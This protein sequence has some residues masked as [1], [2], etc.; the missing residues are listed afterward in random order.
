MARFSVFGGNIERILVLHV[1]MIGLKGNILVF[2]G[3]MERFFSC[4][5][6]EVW[7]EWQ[8]SVFGGNME[9]ILVLH[10]EMIGLDGNILIFDG[11]LERILV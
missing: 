9:R 1:D 3:N 6:R 2:D 5:C 11:N 4:A 8:L 7:P 10:A